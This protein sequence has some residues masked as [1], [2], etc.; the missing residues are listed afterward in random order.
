[1][2]GVV[3]NLLEEFVTQGWGED[4][5]ERILDRCPMKNGAV[6][7]G[8]ETYPDSEL[9]TIVSTA[10][11]E[12]GVEPDVALR[13]F[14]RFMF[15]RLAAKYP[16]F[17]RNHTHPRSFLKTIND[18]IHVEVRKLMRDA[19]PPSIRWSEPSPDELVLTYESSRGLCAVMEGLLAG[20][21]DYFETPFDFQHTACTKNG[22]GRCEFRL[23]FAAS[24]ERAS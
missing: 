23:S 24:M 16:I 20:T 1:M 18:V 13:A 10:C 15:P 6:Y 4:A 9:V 8:P 19:H 7:V 17:V 14:G 5:Y 22:A 2:K 21:A 11:A 3:F 12:L